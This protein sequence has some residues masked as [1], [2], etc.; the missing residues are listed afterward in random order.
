MWARMVWTDP[1]GQSRCQSQLIRPPTSTGLER[2]EPPKD[3]EAVVVTERT[4]NDLEPVSPRHRFAAPRRPS[5]GRATVTPLLPGTGHLLDSLSTREI[6]HDLRQPIAT[7]AALA[8]A[9]LTTADLA[10]PVVEQLHHI[11]EEVR[12]MT[13]LVHQLGESRIEPTL[14]PIRSILGGVLEHARLVYPGSIAVTRCPEVVVN[15]DQLALRRALSNVVDN[16]MRAA[17]PGGTIRV[18]VRR[19]SRWLRIEVAD[20][21]P[22]F[23]RVPPGMAN[24]GLGIA[25]SL[26][27]AHQGRIDIGRSRLGG[28]AVRLCIPACRCVP[29]ALATHDIEV[30][31][32]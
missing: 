12:V 22:G 13:A 3:G 32:G 29:T 30:R 6:C 4:S 21:G 14:V 11:L 1:A 25:E 2:P 24:L 16:A 7:I 15:V 8:E 26:V 27:A 18:S 9:A 17:G 23:G 10:S 20:S 19:G 5:R 28:A 31:A